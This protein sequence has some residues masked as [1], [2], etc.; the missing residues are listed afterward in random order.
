[1]GRAFLF[2]GVAQVIDSTQLVIEA[3]FFL[4]SAFAVG[5]ALWARA[6]GYFNPLLKP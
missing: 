4:L 5:F 3:L 1:M 2:A 6:Q